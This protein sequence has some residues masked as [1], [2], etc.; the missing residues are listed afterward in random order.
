[1]FFHI[2][3]EGLSDVPTV[4][5]IMC[6]RI[7]V[8]EGSHFRVYPHKGKGALPKNLKAVPDLT[9]LGQLPATLRA[10]AK[11][12]QEHCIVVLVDADRDDCKT[13]KQSLVSLWNTINPKPAK[14]VFRIAVEEMESWFIA[15]IKAVSGAYPHANTTTLS[16]IAPD[17]VVGAWERL[18]SA[19]GLNPDKCSGADKEDWAKAISPHL[20]LQ[21][22]N[23]PSLSAFISGILMHWQ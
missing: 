1:M 12:G 18:A 7:G 22:P 16:A 5:E 9:L 10:Y 2:L 14:A 19:I 4:R 21:N 6:R 17:A 3:V 20:N 23:S 8:T 15:D 13:L 11:K